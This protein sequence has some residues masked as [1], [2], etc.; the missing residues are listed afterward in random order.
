MILKLRLL[1]IIICVMLAG[2]GEKQDPMSDWEAGVAKSL[3]ADYVEF[4]HKNTST[5]TDGGP[6]TV[7]NYLELDIYN[8]KTIEEISFNE[9]L[10]SKKRD[11]IKDLMLKVS[12]LQQLPRFSEIRIKFEETHGVFIFS[13]KKVNSFTYSVN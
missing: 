4:F 3:K 1:L 5:S 8:S 7:E 6:V 11:E 10:F 2:C 13:S 12:E 9:H